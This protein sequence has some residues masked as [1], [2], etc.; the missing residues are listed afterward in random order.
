V[1]VA[2]ERYASGVVV[3][4]ALGALGVERREIRAEEVV[5]VVMYA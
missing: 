1:S 5:A 3:N 4:E 2:R